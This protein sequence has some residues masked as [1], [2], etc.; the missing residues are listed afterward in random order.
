MT[1]HRHFI[2]LPEIRMG[3][4]RH[5]KN[6]RQR[7]AA[8]ILY[9]GHAAGCQHAIITSKM[10]GYRGIYVL[11]HWLFARRAVARYKND[12]LKRRI[13]VSNMSRRV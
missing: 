6:K 12:E 8:S 11:S 4:R 2:L 1:S 13:V 5:A 9:I 10:T 3:W 7:D